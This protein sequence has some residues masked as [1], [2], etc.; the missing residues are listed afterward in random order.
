MPQKER[1]EYLRK[2][3]YFGKLSLTV[4]RGVRAA[5]AVIGLLLLGLAYTYV[6]WGLPFLACTTLV[7]VGFVCLV[8]NLQP[9][10]NIA[11]S[12]T[13]R[14]ASGIVGEDAVWRSFFRLPIGYTAYAN[15]MLPSNTGDID[16]VVVGP[17]GIYTVEVKNYEGRVEVIDGELWRGKQSL[18]YIVNQAMREARSLSG[19][20]T[21][22]IG[23]RVY[24]HSLIVFTQNPGVHHPTKVQSSWVVPEHEL[25]KFIGSGKANLSPLSLEGINNLLTHMVKQ[26]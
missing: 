4:V 3:L 17:G 16:F 13:H 25:I 11:T 6:G 26:V 21:H 24:V 9:T 10:I 14:F 19:F 18:R 2:N 12:Y 20:M 22:T 5:A 7:F 8:I 23:H 1:G 15:V